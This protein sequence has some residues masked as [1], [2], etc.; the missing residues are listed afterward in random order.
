MSLMNKD[1]YSVQ[2]DR[3]IYDGRHPVDAKNVVVSITAEDGG[4]IKRGQIIDEA[5][6]VYKLHAEAGVPS[7]IAAEDVEYVA[8][9]TDVIVPCYI[10]GT[11]H[12]DAVIASPELTES[13]VEA[14]RANGIFLK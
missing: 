10:T 4:V 9:D 1:A 5:D 2:P 8:D 12:A 7:C 14:L 6:G 3:L 11:Y 13:N